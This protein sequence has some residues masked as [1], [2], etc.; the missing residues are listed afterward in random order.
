MRILQRGQSTKIQEE[1]RYDMKLTLIWDA[2]CGWCYG[3]DSVFH[4]FMAR[5]PEIELSIISGGLFV[6][7][8]SKPANSYVF[9]EQGNQQI[10]K[11]YGVEFGS[12]YNAV[13]K[14]DMQLNSVHP[15]IAWSVIR[16]ELKAE[17]LAECAFAIQKQF[18]YYGKS[19]SDIDT[20]TELAP[21]FG[22]DAQELENS[23]KEVWNK[24]DAAY[25]DFRE[26][27]RLGA[28]SFPTLLAEHKGKVYDF[29]GSARTVEDLEQN[30]QILLSR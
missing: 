23:L 11:Y 15:A 3:F 7:N 1:K 24:E 17:R 30:Y 14:S 28:H 13:L 2:Y 4:K 26:A 18:F 12:A 8:N 10:E 5:H 6:E 22:L 16:K 9:F 21:Q 27:G 19:L 29:K 20:Y 25:E